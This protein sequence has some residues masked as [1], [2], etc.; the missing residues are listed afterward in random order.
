MKPLI[1]FLF[2]A[3]LLPL[4][5]QAQYTYTTNSGA[6]TIT[7]YSGPGGTVTI[8][9]TINGYPVTSIG[10]AAFQYNNNLTNLIVG[11]NVL[12]LGRNTFAYNTNL[13]SVIIPN[14]VTNIVGGT[15]YNCTNLVSIT[16]GN[17]VLNVGDSSFAFDASLIGLY[18][19]GNAPTF[20]SLTSV[21]Y[22]VHG[23][24]IYYNADTTGWAASYDALSTQTIQSQ[25]SY[26]T[27]SDGLTIT[28]I[29]Y[30][31]S[32][33][34][35]A[36]PAA[37]TGLP[38]TTIGDE[39]FYNNHTVTEIII[40]NSVTSLGDDVF[41]SC[42]DLVRV[43]IADSV[44]SIGDEAFLFCSDLTSIT[45]P[46]SV[47][48]IG[49][50]AFADCYGLKS[51][52]I[53]DSVGS[54]GYDAFAG[55]SFLTSVTI[56]NNVTSIGDDAFANCPN[57]TKLWFQ[58]NAPALGGLNVFNGVNAAAKVYYQAGTTGWGTSYGGA[59][60]APIDVANGILP[61]VELYVPVLRNIGVA[62]GFNF[63]ITGITNET[64]VV[65]GST[66]L[67]NWQP[68]QTNAAPPF[69]FTDSHWTSYPNR[70]YRA[71]Y[72]P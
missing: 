4:S 41:S 72:A 65:E 62:G 10:D 7:G 31:G 46:N 60:N 25:Y 52:T 49:N 32:S 48:S 16:L 67:V 24:T 20:V 35:V 29:R 59:F 11:T 15:F 44:T 47:A 51:V 66:N 39:A 27:N 30:N 45:I 21:F 34:W 12:N 63:A 54:I 50:F 56:G 36:I 58:G 28:I 69:Q 55:E 68:L 14:S 26:T 42:A 23:A 22:A 64:I 5:A 61:T 57:L 13:A 40:P 38:V 8:P 2:A 9:D 33:G 3:L 6:I 19:Q 37:I 71:H 53:P 43:T 70:F 1:I 17:G 18:F